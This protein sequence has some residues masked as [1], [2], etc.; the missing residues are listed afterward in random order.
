MGYGFTVSTQGPPVRQVQIQVKEAVE[1]TRKK[2]E[3]QK[4]VLEKEGGI[5]AVVLD[6]GYFYRL[7]GCGEGK[8]DKRNI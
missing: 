4:P 7:T 5:E 8:G 3:P 2:L 6:C 1:C